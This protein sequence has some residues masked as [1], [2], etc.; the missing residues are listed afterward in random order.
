MSKFVAK[1]SVPVCSSVIVILFLSVYDVVYVELLHCQGCMLA[2]VGSINPIRVFFPQF[3]IV[4]LTGAS[5]M[6]GV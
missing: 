2:D 5:E 3:V 4:V 6:I 1:S